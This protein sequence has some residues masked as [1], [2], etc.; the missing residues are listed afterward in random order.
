MSGSVS[1]DHLRNGA[2]RW[3]DCGFGIDVLHVA[4]RGSPWRQDTGFAVV[5]RM[6]ISNDAEVLVV[7]LLMGWRQ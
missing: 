2:V 7:R 5:M 1:P 4:H 6:I 3:S